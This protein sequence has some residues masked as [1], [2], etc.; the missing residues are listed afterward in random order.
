MALFRSQS[1]ARRVAPEP[2]ALSREILER[3]D[4]V[5]DYH[6]ASKHTYAQVQAAQQNWALDWD[7]KPSPYRTFADFPRTPL[8][9]TIIDASVPTLDLLTV[10]GGA[11]QESHVQPP[12]NLKTLG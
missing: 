11:W 2:A 5:H 1:S 12:K 8:P 10:G 3:I 4:R 6:Q 9:T 7:N